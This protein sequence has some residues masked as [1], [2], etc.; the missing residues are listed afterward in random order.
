[1]FCFGLWEAWVV[2]LFEARVRFFI[3]CLDFQLGLVFSW[4]IWVAHVHSS[5]VL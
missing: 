3:L 1:V 2:D 4:Q 5:F